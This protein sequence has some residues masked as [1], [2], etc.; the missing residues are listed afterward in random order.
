MKQSSGDLF[1]YALMTSARSILARVI[2]LGG[3][4]LDMSFRPS[5]PA[6]LCFAEITLLKRLV[7]LLLKSG[8]N[9]GLQK[10][11]NEQT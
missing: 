1:L 8:P 3:G 6:S 11:Y 4:H 9:L 5:F 2:L 10:M 7:I